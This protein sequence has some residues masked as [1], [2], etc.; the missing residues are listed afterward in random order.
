[1][2]RGGVCAWADCKGQVCWG[3]ERDGEDKLQSSFFEKTKMSIFGIIFFI[4]NYCS[5]SK[6]SLLCAFAY[7]YDFDS[8]HNSN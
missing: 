2:K 6:V 1:M 5:K 4:W 3:K 8:M 7:F